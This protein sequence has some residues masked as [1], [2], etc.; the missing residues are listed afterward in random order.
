MGGGQSR[1]VAAGGEQSRSILGRGGVGGDGEQ[2]YPPQH[3]RIRK[4]VIFVTSSVAHAEAPTL[5][6]R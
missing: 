6:A 5:H 3:Y 2:R 4:I 1:S